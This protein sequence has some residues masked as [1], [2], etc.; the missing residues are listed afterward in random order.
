MAKIPNIIHSN[1]VED[2]PM[3]DEWY[4]LIDR[5]LK[6][7]Q[8]TLADTGIGIPELTNAEIAFLDPTTMGR[9]IFY[10]TDSDKYIV[11]VAGVFKEVLTT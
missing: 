8:Q 9:V 11:N 3:N 4:L 6:V 10:N 1:I 5:L 7:L 2:K